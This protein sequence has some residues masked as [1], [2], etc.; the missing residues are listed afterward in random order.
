MK[1]AIVGLGHIAKFQLEALAHLNNINLVGAYDIQPDRARLLPTSVHFYDALDS[2]LTECES[3]LILVSTPNVTHYELG[4]RVLEHGRSLLLEKPCCQTEAEMAD[5]IATAQ[6]RSQFFAVALHAA[7][8]RDMAWYL[9]QVNA[10][11]IDYGPLS[12]FHIGFFDPYY[13]AGAL[14]PSAQSLG[15][16]WFDSGINALSVI[17]KFIEPAQLKLVE[18]RMTRVASV[19]CSEIQGSATFQFAQGHTFGHGIIE[20]NWTLGLNRK[21][22]HLFYCASNTQV[23]LHH[24]DETVLVHRHGRL[25]LEKNLQNNLPR[26]TNHYVNLFRDVAQ[27]FHDNKRNLDYAVQI[28][29]LLFAA[30]LKQAML[31]QR[32][33]G[34][35]H[36]T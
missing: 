3:D 8:A 15:G 21:V 6:K 5:L 12:G 14:K 22:T 33:E 34:K 20:T 25:I 9:A 4:K 17:G 28:H 2:L 26:L 36:G 11:L 35:P 31:S 10:G 30:R 16:S 18:G 27:R 24:S 1:I 13:E 7:Y 19:P 32:S 29:R 23:T